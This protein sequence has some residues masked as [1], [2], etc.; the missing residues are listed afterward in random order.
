M[1]KSYSITGALIKKLLNTPLKITTKPFRTELKLN[2]TTN[3]G[4]IL[5]S[6]INDSPNPVST[7]K[8]MQE[9]RKNDYYF[10]TRSQEIHM[11]WKISA[12][13]NSSILKINE[14]TITSYLNNPNTYDDIFLF[15]YL[16]NKII[17]ESIL[18]KNEKTNFETKLSLK[19]ICEN[20]D[21]EDDN[22]NKLL[23]NINF[24]NIKCEI[25]NNHLNKNN[26]V[27]TIN[28]L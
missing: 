19:E 25:N 18:I 23:N 16:K 12:T 14:E 3:D 26:N 24:E 21:F 11:P 28:S 4:F 1:Q 8:K 15:N 22:I 20:F 5:Q 6:Y 27:N 17:K 2:D 13:I 7:S 9:F 10:I